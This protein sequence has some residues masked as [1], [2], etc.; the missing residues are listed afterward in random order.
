MP[1]LGPQY[2][3]SGRRPCAVNFK[4]MLK[5]QRSLGLAGGHMVLKGRS[6]ALWLRSVADPGSTCRSAACCSTTG[7]SAALHS[8]A[9]RSIA[10]RCDAALDIVKVHRVGTTVALW[11][12][13]E[14]GVIPEG[15]LLCDHATCAYARMRMGMM[16]VHLY[17]R[18]P[19]HVGETCTCDPNHLCVARKW[20]M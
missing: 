1:A 3:A 2:P 4:G 12:L 13:D 9:L 14:L 15:T 6:V 8:V 17:Q 18:A 20:T 10:D 16:H 7:R 19:L 11:R 5:G